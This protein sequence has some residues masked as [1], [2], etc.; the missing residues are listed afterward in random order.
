MKNTIAFI[1]ALAVFCGGCWTWQLYDESRYETHYETVTVGFKGTVYAI[2]LYY[3]DKQDRYNLD[4]FIYYIRDENG[5]HNNR[6]LFL[7]PNDVL[8]VPLCRLKGRKD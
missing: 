8:R 4:E 2:A 3:L 7:Q 1:L 5:L 6:H